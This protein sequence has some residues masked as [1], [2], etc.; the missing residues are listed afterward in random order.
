[1]NGMTIEGMG[2]PR[3]FEI[4]KPQAKPEAGGFADTLKKA[5]S[6]ANHLQ[7]QSDVAMQ[8]VVKGDLGIHEGMMAI[9][10]ADLSLRLLVQVRNKVMDAY[11]EISR[12]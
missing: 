1:M 12:M 8:D 9:S 7:Q 2:A 3:A 6:Q 4:N 11:K 10:E 5:L